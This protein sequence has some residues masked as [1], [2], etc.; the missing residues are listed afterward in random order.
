MKEG[1]VKDNNDNVDAVDN[2]IAPFIELAAYG[3]REHAEAV[4]RGRHPGIRDGLQWLTYAHLPLELQQYSMPFYDA[5]VTLIERIAQDSPELTTAINKLIES[6]D[7]AVRAGIRNDHGRA[8]SVGRSHIV[9]N[10]NHI[11][12]T[13]NVVGV[14]L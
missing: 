5:A 12:S 9:V 10:I 13:D 11:A 14:R 8:G 6:K 1:T 4:T 7:S 3:T 2:L